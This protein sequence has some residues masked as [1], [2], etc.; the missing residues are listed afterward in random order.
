MKKKINMKLRL[1]KETLRN[2]TEQ[3]LKAAAGGATAVCTRYCEPTAVSDCY[4][5]GSYVSGGSCPTGMA[6]C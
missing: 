5:C 2:L 6:C 4:E 3:D 1:N